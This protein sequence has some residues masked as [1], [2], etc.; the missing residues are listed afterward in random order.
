[1]IC[2]YCHWGWP[3]ATRDIYNRYVERIGEGGMDFGPGHIVWSDENF[4]DQSIRWCIEHATKYRGDLTDEESRLAV[5]ALTELLAVPESV[6][7]CEP[8]DYDG[9]RPENYPPPNGIEMAGRRKE[10]R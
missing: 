8:D 6:R 1:M 10:G 9:Y 5:A 3:K 4:D 2:W 7:C